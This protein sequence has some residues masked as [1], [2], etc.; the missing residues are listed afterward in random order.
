MA[1]GR[2]PIN[3]IFWVGWQQL[4]LVWAFYGKV[5]KGT[6]AQGGLNHDHQGVSQQL[7]T[8]LQIETP[9]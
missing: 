4:A 1:T 8:L 3:H 2:L 6:N 5:P 7:H 9:P